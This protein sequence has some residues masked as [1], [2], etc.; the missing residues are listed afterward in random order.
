MVEFQP[1]KLAAWVRFPSPAPSVVSSPK[2]R[3]LSLL[4]FYLSRDG[5]SSV[6]SFEP[7]KSLDIQFVYGAFV[8]DAH[9]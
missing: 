6:L 8:F 1:S 9:T 7:Y 2:Y 3:V 4:F 5:E